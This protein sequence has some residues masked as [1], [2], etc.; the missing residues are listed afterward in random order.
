MSAHDL[1]MMLEFRP[2]VLGELYPILGI[3]RRPFFRPGVDFQRQLKEYSHVAEQADAAD[4]AV[5]R[6][7]ALQS[8]ALALP[9]QPSMIP[10]EE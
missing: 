8:Q 4:D 6:A 5:Q 2:D 10:N 1:G 3:A 7:K 9:V